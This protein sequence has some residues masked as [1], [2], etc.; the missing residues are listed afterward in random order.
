MSEGATRQIL[1]TVIGFASRLAIAAL[2]E[3]NIQFAP[4]L[5]RAGLSESELETPHVRGYCFARPRRTRRL[6]G[7]RHDGDRAM[8][9]AED[10]IKA[11]TARADAVLA[12]FEAP[13]QLT[14]ARRSR[15]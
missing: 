4:L 1:P 15:W 8:T 5:K 7:I 13:V 2:Q 10:R 14:D 3:R 6:I 11:A 9:E 12:Q